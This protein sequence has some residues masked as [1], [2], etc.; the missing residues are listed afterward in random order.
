M[1]NPDPISL[2]HLLPGVRRGV[3]PLLI[4]SQNV[5]IVVLGPILTMMF[6]YGLLLGRILFC[7]L[8]G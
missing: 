1:G 3:Y 8:L 6:G 7:N 5:P 4:L 2:L